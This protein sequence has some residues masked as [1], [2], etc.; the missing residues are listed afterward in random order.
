MLQMTIG[1]NMR[2][3][4]IEITIF[5]QLIGA[6]TNFQLLMESVVLQKHIT[7][8]NVSHYFK[9]YFILINKQDK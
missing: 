4:A 3:A 9:N 5:I 1:I 7:I 2:Y 8:K 6:L